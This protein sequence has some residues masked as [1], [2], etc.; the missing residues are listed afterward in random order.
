M[1]P[2]LVSL[3]SAV[4]AAFKSGTS[5]L[6]GPALERREA[7]RGQGG[8]RC[9]THGDPGV[10]EAA[11]A[12]PGPAWSKGDGTRKDPEPGHNARR[13]RLLSDSL[14]GETC[15]PTIASNRGATAVV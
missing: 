2:F 9:A 14:T 10:E 3:G 8:S 4:L 13:E 15:L 11:S 7:R 5:H 6:P 1:R 12:G